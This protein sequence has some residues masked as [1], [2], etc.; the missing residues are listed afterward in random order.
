MGNSAIS[1]ILGRGRCGPARP[2]AYVDGEHGPAR[3]QAGVAVGEQRQGVYALEVL[4]VDHAAGAV[5]A[6]PPQFV[7]VVRIMVDE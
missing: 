1:A 2:A 3:G 7:P 4:W 6:Y 5:G